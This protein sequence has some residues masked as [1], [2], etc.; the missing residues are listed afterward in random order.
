MQIQG[1]EFLQSEPGQAQQGI[2]NQNRIIRDKLVNKQVLV[3]RGIYK[4]QRGRVT[5]MNGDSATVEMSIR[6]K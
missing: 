3:I 1:Q 4:G 2:A 5:H 6:L